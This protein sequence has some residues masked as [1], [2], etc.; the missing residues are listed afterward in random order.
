[1]IRLS[2]KRMARIL[3]LYVAGDLGAAR[4]QKA[5]QHLTACKACRELADEFGESRSLLAEGCSLPEFGADFYAEIRNTVLDKIA[6]EHSVPKK[7]IFGRPWIYATS[8]AIAV[9]ASI[10]LFQHFRY[11]S[12]EMTFTPP[13][14]A[15]ILPPATA[16]D[17]PAPAVLSSGSQRRHRDRLASA[18]PRRREFQ[19]KTMRRTNSPRE[20]REVAQTGRLGTKV[21]PVGP[22]SAAL[23]EEPV[24]STPAEATQISRIEIQT[25]DPNIRII[26]FGPQGHEEG[27]QPTHDQIKQENR[28]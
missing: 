25:A 4:Q 21:K 26:W 10:F 19:L 2:C 13:A 15:L 14:A 8:I 23:A 16:K 9:I 6:V 12:N 24:A 22:P 7:T 28:K 11:G 5:A 3:P 27:E 18:D 17:S 20:D 1:M